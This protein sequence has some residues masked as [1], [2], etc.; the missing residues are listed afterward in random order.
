MRSRLVGR[1]Q[2]EGMGYPLEHG[3]LGST[4][5]NAEL[6]RLRAERRVPARNNPKRDDVWRRTSPRRIYARARHADANALAIGVL[7]ASR[8]GRLGARNLRGPG[9]RRNGSNQIWRSGRW[10]ERRGNP[11]WPELLASP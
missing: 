8:L 9:G 10:S 2:S 4:P 11:A 7:G 1:S 3:T 5:V 6:W